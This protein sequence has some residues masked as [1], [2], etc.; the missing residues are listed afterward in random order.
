MYRNPNDW[1]KVDPALIAKCSPAH[2]EHLVRDAKADIAEMSAK[3][4]RAVDALLE[5]AKVNIAQVKP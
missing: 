3:L 1:A 2:I 5:L 4:D